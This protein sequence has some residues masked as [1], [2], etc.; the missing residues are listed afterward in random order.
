MENLRGNT[1]A[2]SGLSVRVRGL[3]PTLAPA[4]RRVAEEVLRDPAGAPLATSEELARRAGVS[5]TTVTRFCRSLGLSNYQQLR[6]A[7]AA[8]VSQDRSHGWAPGHGS[9]IGPDDPVANVVAGLLAAEVQALENTA[10]TLDLSMIEAALDAIVIAERID[11]YGV[12]GSGAAAQD[13]GRRLH[14]I[15]RPASAWV[16]PHDALA[17]AALLTEGDVAIGISHSGHTRDT[18]EALATARERGATTVAVTNFPRSPLAVA[19][20]LPLI[21]AAAETT[22]RSGA[23][24]GRQA[25]QFVVDLL[26]VGVAQRTYE[27]STAAIAGSSAALASRRA[28]RSTNRKD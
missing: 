12:S 3:L 14:L 27:T 23:L 24:S 5:L 8:E 1:K 19:A 26:Y 4:E 10:A 13:L 17:S 28:P 7:L 2:D 25:Q 11:I 18:V 15:R 9:D 16:D 22:F 6:F 20:D 21:T